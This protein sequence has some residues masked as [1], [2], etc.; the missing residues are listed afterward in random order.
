MLVLEMASQMVLSAE[1]LL[2]SL[3]VLAVGLFNR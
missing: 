1:G 2:A 3:K